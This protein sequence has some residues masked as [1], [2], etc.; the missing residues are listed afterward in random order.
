MFFNFYFKR[1]NDILSIQ[2]KQKNKKKNHAWGPSS[3][4]FGPRFGEPG[5]NNSTISLSFCQGEENKGDPVMANWRDTNGK[6]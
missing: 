1:E 5:L 2:F 6:Q 3:L 4:C